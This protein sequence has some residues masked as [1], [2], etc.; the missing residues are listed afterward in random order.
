MPTVL[1]SQTNSTPFLFLIQNII[2]NIYKNNINN[3]YNSLT[4]KCVFLIVQGTKIFL[5]FQY[6]LSRCL[7]GI[8]SVHS[9]M[10]SSAIRDAVTDIVF[11][12]LSR[13]RICFFLY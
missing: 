10:N 3:S 9:E 11:V 13:K 2:Q 4:I 1:E 6:Y 12:L 5:F 7:V 8:K